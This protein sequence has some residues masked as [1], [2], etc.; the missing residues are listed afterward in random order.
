MFRTIKKLINF[1]FSANEKI[2]F[3][4]IDITRDP[5]TAYTLLRFQ[6]VGKSVISREPIED[7]FNDLAIIEGFSK[8]DSSFI[9]DAYES[10]RNAPHFW[11]KNVIFD[12]IDVIFSIQDLH[13][14]E[15][16]TFSGKFLKTN[17]NLI[18]YFS[19]K[20]MQVMLHL[21]FENSF[22]KEKEQLNLKRKNKQK[23]ILS[24]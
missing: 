9:L 16:F 8:K 23:L 15:E 10:D 7:I 3:K 18:Q 14:G 21:I 19:S 22:I 6:A 24:F 13:T 4:I 12:K 11:L 20:D 1:F 5:H 17:S 2:I